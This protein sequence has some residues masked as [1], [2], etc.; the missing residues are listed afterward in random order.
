MNTEKGSF[1]KLLQRQL[2]KTI[3]LNIENLSQNNVKKFVDLVNSAYHFNN[4]E[5]ELYRRAEEISARDFDRL[6]KELKEKNNFLDTFNHGLSHD[7]KNHSSNIIGLVNMLKKYSDKGDLKKVKII[8]EKLEDSSSQLT[9]IV[10]GF[11]Q[12]SRAESDL[13]E[14]YSPID[15]TN[16]I[17]SIENEIAFLK[18]TKKV[19]ISYHIEKVFFVESTLRIILVNLISNAIKYSKPNQMVI[20]DVIVKCDADNVYLEVKD[21]GI[22]MD[23]TDKN[24]KIYNLFN[25]SN[26]TKGYGVG[27]FLV[28]KITDKHKGSIKI[29]SKL[30]EGTSINIT[31]PKNKV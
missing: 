5:H 27:L 12:I 14:S 7:I 8:T 31:F 3:G 21:N 28:K 18:K 26:A 2:K 4:E 23:L 10:Q 11:L 30:Q 20:I 15:D 16:L 9:T 24:K 17:I 13:L 1:T 25:N 19:K 22:G 29:K 6:N